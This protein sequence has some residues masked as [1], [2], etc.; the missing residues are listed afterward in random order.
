MS[1]HKC[2]ISL[3]KVMIDIFLDSVTAFYMSCSFSE[4]G[5]MRTFKLCMIIISTGLFSDDVTEIQ[6]HRSI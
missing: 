1:F 2:G 5:K 3:R 6:G 4:P